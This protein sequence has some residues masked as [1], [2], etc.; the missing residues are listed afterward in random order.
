MSRR[1]IAWWPLWGAAGFLAI[2]LALFYYR[3]NRNYFCEGCHSRLIRN[4]SRLGLWTVSSFPISRISEDELPS[5]L[6]RD[7]LASGHAHEWVF[8]QGSPYGVFGWGGCAV[9]GQKSLG[10]LA[11]LY[12]NDPKFRAFAR[13]NQADG[14]LTPTDFV[15]ACLLQEPS[16]YSDKGPLS[17]EA[18]IEKESPEI[19]RLRRFAADLEKEFSP[20]QSGP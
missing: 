1:A 8:T 6:Y 12:E 10:N 3:D 16:L 13:K 15:A 4:Q 20:R 5:N 17:R 19:Q 9:G 7:Y 11:Y 18:A 2:L 14:K